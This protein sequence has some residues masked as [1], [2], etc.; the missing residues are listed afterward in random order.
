MPTDSEPKVTIE[1]KTK[2]QYRIRNPPSVCF[3]RLTEHKAGQEKKGMNPWNAAGRIFN[4][5]N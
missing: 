3:L 2:R 4:F 1:T 5:A